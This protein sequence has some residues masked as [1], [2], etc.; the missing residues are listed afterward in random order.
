MTLSQ[1]GI[2][3]VLFFSLLPTFPWA[4][5]VQQLEI[6][7]S[8]F[9]VIHYYHQQGRRETNMGP[10]PAQIWRN[11]GLVKSKIGGEKAALW[12][13]KWCDLQKKKVFTEILTIFPAEIRWSAK[14]IRL[15]TCNYDGP[16][17][18]QCHL[19]GPLLEL[20]GPEV[21]LPLPPSRRPWL[22]VAWPGGERGNL[23]PPLGWKV[24]KIARF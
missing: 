17:T 2:V 22:S 1:D 24:C 18:S 23:E 9:T 20:M 3:I 16:F 10:G 11:S 5:W 14:D 12:S 8:Q 4:L 19:D 13:E 21:I 7:P 6:K 15:F